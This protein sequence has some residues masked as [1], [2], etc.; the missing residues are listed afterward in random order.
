MILSKTSQFT[1]AAGETPPRL[2]F[3]RKWTVPFGYGT[4]TD[5]RFLK[6]QTT[7]ICK[8]ICK[9]LIHSETTPTTFDRY[10]L[11][12]SVIDRAIARDIGKQFTSHEYQMGFQPSIAIEMA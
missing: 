11:F 12:L 2:R 3:T 6:I 10:V 7:E 5:H 1:R 8:G 4:D 9:E